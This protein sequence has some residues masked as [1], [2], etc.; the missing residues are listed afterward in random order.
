MYGSI[1]AE[2]CLHKLT[3]L[4]VQNDSPWSYYASQLTFN[5]FQ[6]E[7]TNVGKIAF[8]LFNTLAYLSLSSAL[9]S[10]RTPKQKINSHFCSLS[11]SIALSNPHAH[12][13]KKKSAKPPNPSKPKTK[14]F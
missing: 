10:L 2:S 5:C 13:Q 1:A 8:F 6:I 3:T 11:L 4:I 7:C 9:S 14:G 12:K